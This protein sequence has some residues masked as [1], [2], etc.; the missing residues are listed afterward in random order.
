MTLGTLI[1][2]CV[3]GIGAGLMV[4]A[5]IF[6]F[7]QGFAENEDK[8]LYRVGLVMILVGAAIAI[9]PGLV[10]AIFI[11]GTLMACGLVVAAFNKVFPDIRRIKASLRS[12]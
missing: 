9:F 5:S 10:L 11:I 1:A 2:G 4:L 3:I 6:I 12:G 8:V 7:R